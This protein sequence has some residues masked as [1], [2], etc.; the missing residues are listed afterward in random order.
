MNEIDPKQQTR[1]RWTLIILVAVFASPIILAFI[2]YKNKWMIPSGRVSH[3]VIISPAQPLSK[4]TVNTQKDTKFG[5][6]DIRRKWSYIYV[7]EKECDDACQLNLVK[8]RNARI[9]QGAEGRRVNYYL[10]LTS[11][12][13][14]DWFSDEFKKAHPKLKILYA[15]SDGAKSLLKTLKGTEQSRI[16]EMKRVYMIDPL[17]NYMMFYEDGFDSLGIME[18]LKLL[19][20]ASQIG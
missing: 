19:L 1:S 14:V 18:D 9:G 17:G 13:K 6:E 11:E 20:K 8:M 12:T 4:F 10:I 7:I 15:N 3:G 16:E 5:L 2:V